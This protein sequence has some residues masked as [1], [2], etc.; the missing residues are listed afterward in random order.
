MPVDQYS[1]SNDV[2]E[3]ATPGA[4]ERLD[5]GKSVKRSFAADSGPF[6]FTFQANLGDVIT[7]T[8]VADRADP[9]D[10]AI[11]L[12]GPDG[13]IVARNDDSFDLNF[14]LTNA[15]LVNFPIPSTGLYT[16]Q[17]MRSS[18]RPGSFTLTLRG[19]RSRTT[20]TGLDYGSSAD[21]S[22]SAS[23]VR[24]TFQFRASA[25]DVVTIVVARA[26]SSRLI[27]YVILFDESGTKLIETNPAERTSG[28]ARITRYP[29][30]TDGT[31]S[32]VVSRVGEERGGSSGAFTLNLTREASYSKLT[33]GDGVGGTIDKTSTETGYIFSAKAGDI[34][35]ITMTRKSG[36]LDS[37]LGLFSSDGSSVAS[38]DNAAG[39]GLRTGD[40]QIKS[41]E[42][43][44][45]GAYII[46]A[47]RK[48]QAK[49]TTSGNFALSLELVTPGKP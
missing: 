24:T 44:D 2:Q 41:F 33:Y 9:M 34:V 32:I 7:L 17:A 4:P 39:P 25:G 40:A 38:N 6:L 26:A 15:R 1:G 47:G 11:S 43:P 48:G 23:V 12:F 30:L 8:M 21:G 22:V 37:L 3:T 28:T 29:I 27:P 20:D 19:T 16:I 13:V 5:Y 49:G 35:T 18:D 10:P 46:L 31:Y 36:N 45:T 14:G 42:I